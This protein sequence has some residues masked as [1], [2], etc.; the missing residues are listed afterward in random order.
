MANPINNTP[1]LTE[2]LTEVSNKI[3]FSA[4]P[5]TIKIVQEE[6]I[7][8]IS[9]N[10]YFS[11]RERGAL[12]LYFESNSI[13]HSKKAQLF[14]SQLEEGV[15]EW[16]KSGYEK[17]KKVFGSIKEYVSRLWE[18]IKQAFSTLMKKGIAWVQN[19]VKTVQKKA[20]QLFDQYVKKIDGDELF[21]EVAALLKM[22]KF[23]A[24][25]SSKFFEIISDLVPNI[26]EKATE[27]LEAEADKIQESIFP[28]EITS[29][30]SNPRILLEA[31]SKNKWLKYLMN[32]IK[33]ILNPVIGTIAVVG[34]WV[35]EEGLT[36]ASKLIAKLGGPSAFT[37]HILPPLTL[38]IM[39][40]FGKFHGIESWVMEFITSEFAEVIPGLD[41]L[42]MLWDMGSTLLLTYAI[43]EII[44]EAH[45]AYVDY[46]K[47]GISLR[48]SK[49][50][51]EEYIRMQKLAG[52]S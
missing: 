13:I 15:V 8:T 26:E 2:L 25:N 5:Q 45:T 23:I 9:T 29:H 10:T 39:E 40:L 7:K 31:E 37:F 14:E 48:K 18:Q 11:E 30:L 1:S 3:T 4:I 47:D 36:L 38:A 49:P 34:K 27:K 42:K 33:I 12:A 51:S 35:G 24:I 16:F 22:G 32:I 43:Y 19:T 6:F 20:K 44:K 28:S 41:T 21:N 46:A 17:V 50:V 52:L